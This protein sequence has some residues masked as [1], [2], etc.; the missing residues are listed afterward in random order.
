MVN[1]HN[2]ASR[3]SGYGD[4]LNLPAEAKRRRHQRLCSK[5]TE[6][7]VNG[8]YINAIGQCEYVVHMMC[9]ENSSSIRLSS[10]TFDI[11]LR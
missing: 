4:V 9:R 1:M 10:I 6:H 3:V 8:D 11:R 5:S 2:A 7:K